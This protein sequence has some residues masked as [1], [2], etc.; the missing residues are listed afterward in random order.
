MLNHVLYFSGDEKCPVTSFTKYLSKLNPGNKN[1]WQ[2][3]KT[4]EYIYPATDIWYDNAAVGKNTLG[5]M[6]SNVSDECGL[7][8]RYTNHCIRSTC[9][10]ALDDGG[11]ETRHI[12]ASVVTNPK[13][14]AVRSYTKK[15]SEKKTRQMSSVLS[16]TV[17]STTTEAIVDQQGTIVTNNVSNAAAGPVSN[18]PARLDLPVPDF[19]F[20]DYEL[21]NALNDITNFETNNNQLPVQNNIQ[22]FT[23]APTCNFSGFPSGI[24]INNSTVNFYI[25]K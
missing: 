25:Q 6:M 12:W 24:T 7:S 14:S 3:P 16:S 10:T 13:E 8:K 21:V 20:D 2:R 9:I 18:A 1:F 15:L 4:K 11:I 23:N 19:L 5:S 17:R 22:H